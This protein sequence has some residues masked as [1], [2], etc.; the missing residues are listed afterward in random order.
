MAALVTFPKVTLWHGGVHLEHRPSITTLLHYYIGRD[1]TFPA[2]TS[3]D[4]LL[5][6][7]ERG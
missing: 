4:F 2:R 5:F 1:R 3:V 6:E 7:I